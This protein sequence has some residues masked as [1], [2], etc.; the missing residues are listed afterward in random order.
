MKMLLVPYLDLVVISARHKKRLLLVEANATDRA[1]VLI[2]LVDQ[3]AHAV[4]PQLNHA[5]VQG[6]QNPWSLGVEGQACI[7]SFIRTEKC[8]R[9]QRLSHVLV[10]GTSRLII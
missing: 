6:G 8:L 5:I 9:N 3:S 4:V 10:A 7:K 2:K 1:I